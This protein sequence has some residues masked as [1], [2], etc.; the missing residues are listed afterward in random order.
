MAAWA[1]HPQRPIA[2]QADAS[3]RPASRP[4]RPPKWGR[5]LRRR[6]RADPKGRAELGATVL[7]RPSPSFG[8]FSSP[9]VVVIECVRN[10]R[11]PG[12]SSTRGWAARWESFAAHE[13]RQIPNTPDSRHA[14]L[15]S[16]GCDTDGTRIFQI[17][18][19]D[20]CLI[21]VSSVAKSRRYFSVGPK[22]L[23]GPSSR[24]SSC[25]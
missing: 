22:P 17:N 9:G 10:R 18:I 2:L 6:Q 21:R 14:E 23:H 7:T 1:R 12:A 5:S 4:C 13:I 25:V 16:H 24:R 8:D 19:F 15:L 3:I 11:D 20:P